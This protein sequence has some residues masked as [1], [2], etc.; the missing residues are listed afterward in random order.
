MG[1][2]GG[3]CIF[4]IL[5]VHEMT[6]LIRTQS[7]LLIFWGLSWGMRKKT[8]KHPGNREI[9]SQYLCW[10]L[11]SWELQYFDE[12]LGNHKLFQQRNYQSLMSRG[13][14]YFIFLFFHPVC[15]S[16]H[17]FRRNMQQL[18]RDLFFNFFI[19]YLTGKWDL[20]ICYFS[21]ISAR[22]AKLWEYAKSMYSGQHSIK[23]TVAWNGF[24][25]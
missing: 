8:L 11:P 22:L 15:D 1:R 6:Q 9:M 21:R 20:K 19:L 14:R 16:A 10:A 12:K 17:C 24:L 4:T 3:W 25:A 7:Q 2:R 18:Y 23:G 13:R 5:L